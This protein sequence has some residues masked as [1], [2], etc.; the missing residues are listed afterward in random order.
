[1][2][3]NSSPLR[4]G[5]PYPPDLNPVEHAF[6]KRRVLL[7]AAAKRTVEALWQTLGPALDAFTSAQSANYPAHAG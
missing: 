2:R 4:S 5:T 6:A 3:P 1:M 7:S